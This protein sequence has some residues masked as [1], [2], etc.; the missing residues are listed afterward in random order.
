MRK[1][2][3]VHEGQTLHLHLATRH[4]LMTLTAPHLSKLH[5]ALHKVAD[6]SRSRFDDVFQH[7][8]NKDELLLSVD[9]RCAEYIQQRT[10]VIAGV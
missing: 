3:L 4:R 6:S 10:A 8:Q 5:G 7:R 9:E 1:V 2:V